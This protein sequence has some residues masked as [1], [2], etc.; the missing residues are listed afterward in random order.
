MRTPATLSQKT[1]DSVFLLHSDEHSLPAA[2]SKLSGNGRCQNGIF[3]LSPASLRWHRNI[4]VLAPTGEANSH[5]HHH[6]NNGRS[7]CQPVNAMRRLHCKIP[8][9]NTS[10]FNSTRLMSKKLAFSKP[11]FRSPLLR[12]NS[13]RLFASASIGTP[14]PPKAKPTPEPRV[15]SAPKNRNL[16]LLGILSCLV[17]GVYYRAY[18]LVHQDEFDYPDVQALQKE[19]DEEFA[20]RRREQAKLK[21]QPS[22]A[23]LLPAD[24]LTPKPTPPTENGVEHH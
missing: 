15:P 13:R 24:S 5:S 14:T 22:S 10:K 9:T 16:V 20:I 12:F 8:D 7:T 6:N 17:L 23:R 11:L 1:S 21:L 4:P 2:L 19:L 18:S 3:R